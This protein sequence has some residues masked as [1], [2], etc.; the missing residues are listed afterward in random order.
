MFLKDDVSPLFDSC[1]KKS[2]ISLKEFRID[3]LR[4][5]KIQLMSI[6]LKPKN[7]SNICSYS[8]IKL[9]FK[10]HIKKLLNCLKALQ[11]FH[12]ER[13]KGLLLDN[14]FRVGG[15]FNI[16]A[17]QWQW[18]DGSMVFSSINRTETRVEIDEGE[19]LWHELD[20]FRDLESGKT[21]RILCERV[22]WYNWNFSSADPSPWILLL[23]IQYMTVYNI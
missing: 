10:M 12:T 21:E 8:Y 6:S 13:S 14:R 16:T 1:K 19:L 17:G 15:T 23:N 5:K 22:I 9:F 18:S 4:D 20:I 2:L 7:R 11:F 3:A